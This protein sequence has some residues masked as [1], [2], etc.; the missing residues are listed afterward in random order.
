MPARPFNRRRIHSQSLAIPPSGLKGSA[1][2]CHLIGDRF[3][4]ERR[5]DCGCHTQSMLER[6]H[7]VP[8]G[9][10]VSKSEAPHSV[11]LMPIKTQLPSIAAGAQS[12]NSNYPLQNKETVERPRQPRLYAL[13]VEQQMPNSPACLEINADTDS[14]TQ[15]A[16]QSLGHSTVCSAG[17]DGQHPQCEHV[18]EHVQQ[19][20]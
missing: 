2:G 10:D 18:G 7:R 11:K 15:N 16:L 8:Q 4:P 5:A 19:E 9:A 1:M 6:R 3:R 13:G 20:W 12:T 17:P 14:R